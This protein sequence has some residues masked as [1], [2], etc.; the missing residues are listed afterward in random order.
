MGVMAWAAV[1]PP[2]NSCT[3]R[4]LTVSVLTSAMDRTNAVAPSGTV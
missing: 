4:A 2:R 1:V 3:V